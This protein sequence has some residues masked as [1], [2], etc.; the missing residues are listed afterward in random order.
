M[1]PEIAAVDAASGWREYYQAYCDLYREVLA[2]RW[3]LGRISPAGH[4]HH[5]AIPDVSGQ[6]AGGVSWAAYSQPSAETLLA[7]LGVFR[8]LIEKE[9]HRATTNR[10]LFFCL[11]SPLPDPEQVRSA[12]GLWSV[13]LVYS[14][15]CLEEQL[16][17]PDWVLPLHSAFALHASE[18]I[19]VLDSSNSLDGPAA[20]DFLENLTARMATGGGLQQSVTDMLLLRSS[21]LLSA[22][23]VGI[24]AP[25]AAMLLGNGAATGAIV[26]E[27]RARES[28]WGTEAVEYLNAVLVAAPKAV[29]SYRIQTG[30]ILTRL[31]RERY[32]VPF[33]RLW[34]VIRA[35]NPQIEDPNR[36]IAGSQIQ[37]PEL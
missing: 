3:G 20:T 23:R 22:F 32:G 8:E 7:F 21:I 18:D 28:A 27:H 37:L 13:R 25:E 11:K 10:Y 29:S 2:R 35:L 4:I 1:R 12:L 34:P 5:T 9:P 30:D 16:S 33:E 24:G 36:I 6:V 26:A 17:L 19:R 31:V 14:V 15:E